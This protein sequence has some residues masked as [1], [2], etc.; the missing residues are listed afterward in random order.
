[1]AKTR[2]FQRSQNH[3]S[4]LIVLNDAKDKLITLAKIIFTPF[5]SCQEN[6]SE[7]LIHRGVDLKAPV[8]K[9]RY[10]KN[11]DYRKSKSYEKTYDL[12]RYTSLLLG[13]PCKF[14]LMNDVLPALNSYLKF[15]GIYKDFAL[16][17][18]VVRPTAHKVATVL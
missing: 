8:R 1:M 9:V 7:L 6:F 15:L 10:P 14:S 11:Y 18:L 4:C 13:S 3:R 2:Q 16:D 12:H 5:V 17:Q